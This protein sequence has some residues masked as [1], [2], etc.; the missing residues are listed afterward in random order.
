MAMTGKR[1]KLSSLSDRL[2]KKGSP[3][4]AAREADDAGEVKRDAAGRRNR[5]PDGRKG[6]L[7]RAR[8]K[9]GRP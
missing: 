3:A 8:P 4:A 2:Q 7:I 1:A 9:L 6:I 5:Q